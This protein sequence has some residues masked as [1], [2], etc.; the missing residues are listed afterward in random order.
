VVAA[1]Q[2][3][4]DAKPVGAS[5][6]SVLGCRAQ[7]QALLAA[8]FDSAER[9]IEAYRLVEFRTHLSDLRGMERD[10]VVAE[11]R[12]RASVL[13]AE[14]DLDKAIASLNEANEQEKII[15]K[16]KESWRVR[17]RREEDHREQK[18]NDEVSAILYERQRLKS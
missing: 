16:H 2:Q 9:G 6:R 1:N 7:S 3:L 5:T 18:L 15:E 8:M 14:S 10:L 17:I 13:R 4:L 11:E 12:Q